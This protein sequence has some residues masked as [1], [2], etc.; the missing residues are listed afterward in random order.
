MNTAL[1]KR[2]TKK[3]NK[4][5]KPAA[6]PEMK[7]GT[8]VELKGLCGEH[9]KF[10]GRCCLVRRAMG[11]G[12]YRLLLSRSN[13]RKVHKRNISEV[14]QCKNEPKSNY[15]A[16]L[17]W[18]PI[19]ECKYPS[20]QWLTD[21]IEPEEAY[22]KWSIKLEKIRN[23][24][25]KKHES[26][27]VE[28]ENPPACNRDL[29]F[30]LYTL[31]KLGWQ[32]GRTRSTNEFNKQIIYY[33]P[34]SEG[35]PNDWV[36]DRYGHVHP[37][38]NYLKGPVI[39]FEMLN[40]NCPKNWAT[41][42]FYRANMY[43]KVENSNN[44][45]LKP[46]QISEITE[47]WTK[48]NKCVIPNCSNCSI[49]RFEG[50]IQTAQG[51]SIPTEGLSK[52]CVRLRERYGKQILYVEYLKQLKAEGITNRSAPTGGGKFDDGQEFRREKRDQFIDKFL[53]NPSA[54]PQLYEI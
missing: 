3:S 24:L 8:C 25:L 37:F 17:V 34:T 18:P 22:I 29:K 10:N 47:N 7:P 53:A 15:K 45:S 39:V 49:E 38:P 51:L 27:S 48:Q 33:D 12:Y 42:N 2:K 19:K 41:L 1:K 50:E 26:P 21:C 23:K 4:K 31:K 40:D 5:P 30:N 46:E 6:D 36:M 28:Q 20:I 43:A 44:L 52:R 54:G 11:D 32:P 13:D 16:F 14:K 35:K 9:A